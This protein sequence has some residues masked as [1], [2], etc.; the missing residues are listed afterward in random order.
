MGLLE[1]RK[2][3][4]D[5]VPTVAAR[6]DGPGTTTSVKAIDLHPVNEI[7]K[8]M[9]RSRSSI[10]H[11][12]YRPGADAKMGKD[13]FTKHTFAVALQVPFRI[14]RRVLLPGSREQERAE[15]V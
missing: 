13:S 5:P 14:P 7:T 6:G 11:M 1:V 9:R 3:H 15:R 8:L 2:R 10:R 4:G 12:L